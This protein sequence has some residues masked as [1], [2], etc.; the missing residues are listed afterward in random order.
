[1]VALKDVRDHSVLN[2]NTPI[3]SAGLADGGLPGKRPAQ[4]LDDMSIPATL[5]LSRQN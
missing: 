2:Q 4:K 5:E 1:M 3:I